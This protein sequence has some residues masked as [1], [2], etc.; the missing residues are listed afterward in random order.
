MEIDI[1]N[2]DD[3]INRFMS[4]EMSEDEKSDFLTRLENDDKLR[5]RAQLVGLIAREIHNVNSDDIIVDA[6]SKTD[7]DEFRKKLQRIKEEKRES[8]VSA[9]SVDDGLCI[10]KDENKNRNM[11]WRILSIA[12]SILI[13]LGV[14]TVYQNF[15][16]ADY[17]S[18]GAKQVVVTT[19]RSAGDSLI[20]SNLS[21]LSQRIIAG[22]NIDEAISQLS[23]YYWKDHNEDLKPFHDD[24]GWN[25]AVAYLKV[26]DK[27]NAILVLNNMIKE[28]KSQE[29]IEKAKELLNDINNI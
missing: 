2:Q 12:A 5:Q 1:N 27:D 29:H 24:I 17:T 25:L 16:R 6:L 7:K 26:N 8:K 4:G 19:F 3:I 18:L 22:D 15:N 11:R 20:I 13:V 21:D 23:N 28:S 14:F 10:N 9:C